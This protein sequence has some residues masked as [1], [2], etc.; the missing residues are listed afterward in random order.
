MFAM[1][2]GAQSIRKVMFMMGSGEQN[3]YKMA[4]ATDVNRRQNVHDK[5][6]MRSDLHGYCTPV[7]P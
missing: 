4:F 5:T 3:V 6:F 1:G 2:D 7:V